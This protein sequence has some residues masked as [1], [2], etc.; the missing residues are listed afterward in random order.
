MAGLVLNFALNLEYLEAEFYL[1]ALTGNGLKDS[2]IDGK[3]DLGGVTG[4][5]MVSFE[6]KLGRQ[7]AEEIAREDG[8]GGIP[9]AELLRIFEVGFRGTGARTPTDRA[10]AGLGLAVARGLVHAQGGTLSIVDHGPGCRAEIRLPP[11]DAH[12]GPRPATPGHT[13]DPTWAHRRR[14]AP[15]GSGGTAP[16]TDLPPLGAVDGEVRSP[17]PAV[18]ERRSTTH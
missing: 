13:G 3:G 8:C 14:R 1:R 18:R 15:D 6:T 7:H 17:V 5:Y 16:P 11:P 4:G 10:W 12:P 9:D 2:Q